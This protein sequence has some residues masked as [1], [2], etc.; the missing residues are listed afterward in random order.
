VFETSARLLELLALLESRPHWSG[1]ELAQRLDVGPRTVRRDVERLRRLGYP[2]EATPGVAG[3]YRLGAGASMP[4]LLLDEGEAVAVAVG[5]RTA[6][7]GS[8]AGIEETSLR[9]LGKLDRILPGHLRRRVRALKAFTVPLPGSGPTVDAE[10]LATIA[11]ACRDQES[12]RFGYRARDGTAS[13]RSVEPHRVVHLNGRW[14]LVA[15]DPSRDAWRSFR[16]DRIGTRLSPGPRF[17]ER[18]PP[19]GDAAA[20]VSRSVAT[21]G[22]RWAAEIVLHAPIAEARKRVPPQ[23]GSLTPIDANTCLL[24]AAEDWLGAL[25]IYVANIGFEFEV[26]EPPE[27]VEA[28]REL[29]GRFARAVA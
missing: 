26:R 25:A 3:G 6:A 2:V 28:V 17:A 18:P 8:V 7:G 15:W 11:A 1:P 22:E 19:D 4:P 5:L 20:F 29:A 10:V 16:V 12:L 27:L 21:S 9:A 24:R 13:R 23:H 14:Y